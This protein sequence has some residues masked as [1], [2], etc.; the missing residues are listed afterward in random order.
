MLLASLALVAL[1]A[2]NCSF[3]KHVRKAKMAGG[4]EMVSVGGSSV[5]FFCGSGYRYGMFGGTRK[6]RCQ[7]Q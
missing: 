7:G 4:S 3:S 1:L 5:T 6:G 2:V